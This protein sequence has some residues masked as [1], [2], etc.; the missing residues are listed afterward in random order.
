MSVAL[1]PWISGHPDRMPWVRK[2]LEYVAG[3][4][5]VWLATGSEVADWY[6]ANYYDAALKQMPFP[7]A[8]P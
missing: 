4:D 2:A 5:D 6:F 3:H 7:A 8:A 1:H